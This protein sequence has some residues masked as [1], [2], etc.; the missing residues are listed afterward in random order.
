MTAAARVVAV[1]AIKKGEEI[2]YDY[3]KIYFNAFIGK[4]NCLCV[5]C[6]ARREREAAQKPKRAAASVRVERKAK[7]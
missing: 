3:G 5:K 1:A 2:T 7:R 4:E 6:V